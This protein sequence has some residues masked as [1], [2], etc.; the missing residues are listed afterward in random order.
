MESKKFCDSNLENIKATNIKAESEIR[1]LSDSSED[2]LILKSDRLKNHISSE[3]ISDS[4]ELSLG[5]QRSYETFPESGALSDAEI[6]YTESTTDGFD[7]YSSCVDLQETNSYDIEN[8]KFD[9]IEEDYSDESQLIEDSSDFRDACSLDSYYEQSYSED[10]NLEAIEVLGSY[11]ARGNYH[12]N[13]S[14]QGNE[15]DLQVVESYNLA[16]V[17]SAVDNQLIMTFMDRLNLIRKFLFDQKQEATTFNRS[18]H[19]SQF[20]LAMSHQEIEYL[21]SECRNIL[22]EDYDMDLFMMEFLVGLIHPHKIDT[23][24][25]RPIYRSV[26]YVDLM[27]KGSSECIIC[28]TNFKKI[29][30]CISLNCHHVFHSKCIDKW[31][32]K[33]FACPTCRRLQI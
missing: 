32:K 29:S 15:S 18:S 9:E 8:R 3:E 19:L 21:K 27:N 22:R 13:N 11:R 5:N 16:E 24:I 23:P 28:F 2:I 26:Q 31:L 10:S 12:L 7:T 1:F 14:R 6:D 33:E 30:M 4:N 17:Y 25:Q 20:L